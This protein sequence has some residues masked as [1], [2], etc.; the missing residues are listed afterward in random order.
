MEKLYVNSSLKKLIL[1]AMFLSI[2]VVLPLFTASVKEIGDSLLPMHIPIL[3]CGLICGAKYGAITGFILPIFRALT[4]GMPPIYPNA[5]WMAFELAT[6]G[7]VIGLLYSRFKQ[8][9]VKTVYISLIVSMISGRVV[10]GVVKT[11]LLG[12]G[13][14]KFGF[15]AFLMGGFVDA[16]PGIVLQLILIPCIMAI[17]NKFRPKS[18]KE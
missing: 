15:Y 12:I 4:F 14:S 9:S 6:Y 17:L 18:E 3:L 16:L 1:S 2:G 7:L 10:W 5:V 13:S 8:K 11:L